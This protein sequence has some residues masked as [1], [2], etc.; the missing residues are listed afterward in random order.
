MFVVNTLI[1]II[2]SVILTLSLCSP[3]VN[4]ESENLKQCFYIVTENQKS[5]EV[6]EDL[7]SLNNMEIPVIIIIDPNKDIN[8][9]VVD[10]L[11]DI[12]EK[13]KLIIILKGEKEFERTP[14]VIKQ[15]N[16]ILKISGTCNINKEKLIYKGEG[17]KTFDIVNIG[18]NPVE[19]MNE[20]KR[21]RTR[22]V[23]KALIVDKESL[24]ISTL[25]L[26]HE[27]L[28]GEYL[29]VFN[30]SLKFKDTELLYRIFTY[31]GDL[32]L[33]FFSI[34]IV[35]FSIAIIIFKKYSK[36]KFLDR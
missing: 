15:Y 13:T 29:D 14:F 24:N 8:K 4:G 25:A 28:N 26:A 27:E 11:K 34:S 10:L 12:Q 3:M 17:K 2:I 22:N 1:K 7:I 32:T 21:I 30:Y 23:N 31:I 5:K 9:K 19:T 20:I 33:V 36:E 35:I 16:N 6:N 18:T